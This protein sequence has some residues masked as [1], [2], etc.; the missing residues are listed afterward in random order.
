ML[1]SY[2]QGDLSFLQFVSLQRAT[3]Y[4]SEAL[5]A[6]K[7]DQRQV[8]RSMLQCLESTIELVCQHFANLTAA[9]GPSKVPKL[10]DH[11]VHFFGSISL[12]RVH[13]NSVVLPTLYN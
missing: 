9:R 13:S 12:H 8:Q 7:L 3:T 2:T 5:R 11:V 4:P 6:K 10:H 1:F